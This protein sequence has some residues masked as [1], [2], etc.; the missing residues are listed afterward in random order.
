LRAI[1]IYSARNIIDKYFNPR[2]IRRLLFS[3]PKAIFTGI[4]LASLAS[5]PIIFFNVSIF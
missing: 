3:S 5:D 1:F 2:H 4:F